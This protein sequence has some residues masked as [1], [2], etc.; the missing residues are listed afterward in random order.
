MG[1]RRKSDQP[2]NSAEY[3]QRRY[4]KGGNSGAGSYG[5]LAAFKANFINAFVHERNVTSVIEFG[6]GDG[7]Q[8]ALANYPA[9]LGFDVADKCIEMCNS[10]FADDQTKSFRNIAAWGRETA[11]LTLSLDVI[12]H[13]IEEH[14][15]Q[16]YM[17]KL[18]ASSERYVIVYASNEDREHP[19]VH[20]RH[21]KFTD[22]VDANRADF[23]LI[24]H[25]PNAYPL[26]DDD[27]NQS[28]SEFFVFEKP[29]P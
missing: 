20:V 22:W 16:D 17:R 9:Y 3:W 15:F 10:R 29:Q 2:F 5:R 1:S 24:Q 26:V 21:R 4:R 6:C 11:D 14:V 12:F 27:H 13:L 7:A 8:L 28:F 23:K 25:A 19:A 18:F